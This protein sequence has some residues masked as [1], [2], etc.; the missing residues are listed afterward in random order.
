MSRFQK[1]SIAGVALLALMSLPALGQGGGSLMQGHNSNAPIDWEAN[2][3]E[4]QDQ[5][6]RVMLTGNVIARQAALTLRAARVTAAYTNSGGIDV[7]RIDATGGVNLVTPRESAQSQVAVYDLDQGIITLIG[8][9]TLRN[10]DGVIN[11]GR[12][13]LDLD[14]GRAVMD[15]GTPGSSATPGRVTG[16]FNVRQGSN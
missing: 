6:Q 3:I 4:V 8:G 14:S 12:L 16:R 5:A 7:H 11:G 9:V 1:A 10:A 2:R 13:V 15:G